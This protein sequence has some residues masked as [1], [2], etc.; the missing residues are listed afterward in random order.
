MKKISFEF[1]NLS[2]IDLVLQQNIIQFRSLA[3]K[4]SWSNRELAAVNIHQAECEGA[5]YKVGEIL[6]IDIDWIKEI[7]RI[8]IN[9]VRIEQL[10]DIKILDILNEGVIDRHYNTENIDINSTQ[11]Y[12]VMREYFEKP[13]DAYSYL[14]DDIHGNGSWERNEW[15]WVYEFELLDKLI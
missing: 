5:L 10:H 1:E 3:N 13:I 14:I 12:E 6:Q 8:K 4:Q 11:R 15:Y 9:A 7:Y 2:L